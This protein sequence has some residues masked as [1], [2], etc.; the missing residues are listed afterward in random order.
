M[1]KPKDELVIIPPRDQVMVILNGKVIL[2]QHDLDDPGNFTIMQVAKSG[3]I[4]F[5][6]ELDHAKSN[7]P[8]VWPVVYSQSAQFALLERST[9]D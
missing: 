5:A 4:L 9:F 6:P 1:T 7:Q 8:L 2:R 3:H